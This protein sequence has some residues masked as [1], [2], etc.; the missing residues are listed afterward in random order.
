[1]SGWSDLE[2]LTCLTMLN[3]PDVAGVVD[4][5][6]AARPWFRDIVNL[7]LDKIQSPLYGEVDGMRQVV[8]EGDWRGCE[9]DTAGNDPVYQVGNLTGLPYPAGFKKMKYVYVVNPT[10]GR[11]HRRPLI[12]VTEEEYNTERSARYGWNPAWGWWDA[13]DWWDPGGWDYILGD[14][15]WCGGRVRWMDKEGMFFLTH[16]PKFA[17]LT[18]RM[19]YFGNVQSPATINFTNNTTN[20]ILG[21]LFNELATLTAA[22]M[23]EA[24]GEDDAAQR[25]MASATQLIGDKWKLNQSVKAGSNSRVLI[26]TSAQRS[27]KGW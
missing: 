12:S 1:M 11:V 5:T 16:T 13:S 8:S 7:A 20:W 22:M 19:A 27:M 4:Y 6:K 18:L 26:P 15:S 3:R 9:T 17:A 23:L 21:N 2:N 14:G 25:M 24:S 10:T